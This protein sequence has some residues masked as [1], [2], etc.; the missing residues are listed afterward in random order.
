VI[1][2]AGDPTM[3]ASLRI[4]IADDD[5]STRELLRQMLEKLGHSVVVVAE[6]GRTLV[7]QCAV[8][9]PDVVIT[10][11]LMADVSGLEAA[12][13]LY[14][15]RPTP[16]VLLSGFCD[17]NVV[18]NAEEKHILVY[19]VK[20]ISQD[21]LEAALARCVEYLATT[22]PADADRGE[23][24]MQSPAESPTDSRYAIEQR[25]ER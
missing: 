4:A 23:V 8:V 5:R 2:L 6:N 17:P 20:P 7:D 22:H 14:R 24:V 16:I 10:D 1:S 18:R 25:R 19:L 11:N 3:D 9:E 12:L 13:E 15:A 21:H